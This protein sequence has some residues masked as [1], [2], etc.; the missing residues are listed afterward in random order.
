MKTGPRG[1]ANAKKN[2]KRPMGSTINSASRGN[3][4]QNPKYVAPVEDPEV[5]DPE[6]TGGEEGGGTGDGGGEEGGGTG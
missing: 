2:Y 4:N 5:G 3:S 1:K 6:G